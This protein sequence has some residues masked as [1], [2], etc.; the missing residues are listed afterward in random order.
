MGKRL[1]IAEK[2]S[3]AKVIVRGLYKEKWRN[4]DGY[5]EGQNFV[6]SSAFGHLFELYD[7][8]DYFHRE[9]SKW[10]LEELPIIPEQYKFKI[11]NDPGVKARLK[12]LEKLILRSD[13][14][15]I[16]HAGDPDAEGQKICDDI[17]NYCFEKNNITKKVE[18]LWFSAENEI[19]VRSDIQK[20]RDNSEYNNYYNQSLAR[21]Q[22]D[23]CLG[24]NYTRALS[25]ISAKYGDK[26]LLS[27]G[28]VLG[29]IVKYIY[30]RYIEQINFEPK[31]YTNIGLVMK[32]K[33]K[34]M[35]ILKDSI[36][37]QEDECKALEIMNRLNCSNTYVKSIEQK[38][39]NKQAPNLFSLTSL[40]NKLSK[41]KISTNDT[42][43]YVQKLY[44]KGFLTYPRAKSEYLADTDKDMVSKVIDVFRQKGINNIEFKDTKHIF[45]SSK[46]GNDHSAIIPTLKLPN[47]GELTG[48]EKLV[49]DTVKNRFLANFC[50]EK[51]IISQTKVIIANSD[52]DNN[53]VA[54][55][56]GLRVIQQGFL[57]FE[58]ILSEKTVPNFK[59]GQ[60][61]ECEYQLNY[62]ETKPPANVTPKELNNFMESPF[63]KENETEEEKYKKILEGLEIG[64][65]ATRS[66]IVENAKKYNYIVESKG[67][68]TITEKGIYF[69]ESADK[70]G[71]IMEK[72]ATA[73]IGTQLQAVLDKK[74][75]VK[76]CVDIVEREVADKVKKAKNI[77][78]E[79]YK[80]VIN[81]LGICP[82]CGKKIIEGKKAYYCQG[83]KDGSCKFA[84]FKRDKFLSL[85][86]KTLTPRLVTKLLSNK[87]VKITGLKSK[88]GVKYD[89]DI[90]F[91]QNGDWYNICFAENQESN[92]DEDFG[93]CPRCKKHHIKENSKGYYCTGYKD[94]IKCSF[95]IWKENKLL[96]AK[97]IKFKKSQ[98]KKLINNDRVLIKNIKRK[99]GKGTYNAY[100]TLD[101][102]GKF[103]NYKFE[104][105]E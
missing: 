74:I 59:E 87:V 105:T 82:V 54:E 98:I 42:L 28:R 104:I 22:I 66:G 19:S 83:I 93:L 103:V 76:Q 21:T 61:I 62:C 18:R 32:D 1:I 26:V 91:K 90:T 56:K 55:M 38:E 34:T 71:L 13:I 51:C 73:R 8:D 85:R 6:C 49:Y 58:N 2:P 81:E 45:D 15:G 25:L 79:G 53:M 39:I 60:R 95:M 68:Y 36:F 44:E 88:S 72:E 99:D 5:F 37:P 14:D 57:V 33:E 48:N 52:P 86:G 69:I 23:Y 17:I 80:N 12:L 102:T 7:V 100:V 41:F 89:A 67:V 24:I 96:Q 29:C 30:D 43:T 10:T 70:L 3:L 20:M 92:Q 77:E 9:K 47:D 75:S 40:Q 31:K 101:D 65:P 4:E 27:Q 11:K 97:G 16:I 35:L 63:R 64:T 46:V 78:V 50:T 84:L 94:D